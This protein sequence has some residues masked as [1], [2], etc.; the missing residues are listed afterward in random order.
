MITYA[1]LDNGSTSSFCAESLMRQLG[2]SGSR[3]QISFTTLEKKDSIIDCFVVKG[4]TISDLG[5]NVFIELPAMYTRPEIPVSEEDIPTQ[6]DVNRW[7]H[8]SAVYLPEVNAVIGLLIACDVPT[9]FDPL[10]GKH[11]KDGGPYAPRTSIGWVVNGPLG[12]HRKGRCA[13]SFFVKADPELQC[14]VKDFYD[15]GYN[16]SSADD[17][18]EMSQEELRFLHELEST[19]VLKDSNYEIALSLK[20][21]NVPVSNNR[22]QAEQRVH[23][24]KKKLQRKKNLYEDYKRFM[25]KLLKRGLC[26]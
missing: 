10:E 24:L 25:A 11:S 2:V 5:E 22:L 7:P 21:H 14:M 13:T 3:D 12:H 6:S 8:L 19:V 4:L 18:P 9:V 26:A 23:W 20:D 17:R 15:S 16:E 1:F